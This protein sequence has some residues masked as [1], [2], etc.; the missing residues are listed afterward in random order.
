MGVAGATG[1]A[2][3]V[4]SVG[5]IEI[6]GYASTNYYKQSG[7]S[8]YASADN[9]NYSS[10]NSAGSGIWLNTA[11]VTKVSL[12]SVNGANL[13]SNTAIWVYGMP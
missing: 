10:A 11:A 6:L 8:L 9:V 12:L 4:I 1:I 13:S 3:P 2:S 7:H 5:V